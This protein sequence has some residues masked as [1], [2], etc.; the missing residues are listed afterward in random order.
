MFLILTWIVRIVLVV[1]VIGLFTYHIY[2]VR[3]R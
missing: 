2:D 1:A 3:R